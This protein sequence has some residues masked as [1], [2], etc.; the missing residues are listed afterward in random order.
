MAKKDKIKE[1]LDGVYAAA[2]EQK[3]SMLILYV[4]EKDE[5][6]T[7]LV[8]DES[9]LQALVSSIVANGFKPN[10]QKGTVVAANAIV[11]G[12]K[13]V[14]EYPNIESLRIATRFLSALQKAV[15]NVNSG[16][17][18]PIDMVE[19][20]LREKA[21]EDV[22]DGEDGDDTDDEN[23]EECPANKICPLP[24]AKAYRENKEN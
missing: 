6:S 18:S 8:G 1:M 14:M 12:V 7:Y 21:N 5:P 20:I 9:K 15:E 23:C 2:D 11:D 24:K 10:A 13:T 22:E 17:T 3:D 16:I 19:R 4:N